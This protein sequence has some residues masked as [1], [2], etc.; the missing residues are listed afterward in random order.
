MVSAQLDAGVGDTLVS[1]NRTVPGVWEAVSRQD[2]KCRCSPRHGEG[3]IPVPTVTHDNTARPT[4]ALPGI[5]LQRACS[6]MSAARPGN[7]DKSGI[8]FRIQRDENSS[9]WPRCTISISIWEEKAMKSASAPISLA[10]SALGE[11]R[12]VCALFRAGRINSP[13]AA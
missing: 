7:R 8:A 13:V 12:H 10:G 2:G 5:T 6:L 3:V 4:S 1:V 11:T 9:A